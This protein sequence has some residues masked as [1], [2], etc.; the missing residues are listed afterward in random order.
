M[1]VVLLAP[2]E[3]DDAIGKRKE[4]VIPATT[5]ILP[6]GDVSAALTDYDLAGLDGLTTKDLGAQTLGVGVT[7]VTGSALAFLVS[8]SVPAYLCLY[9]YV[10]RASRTK[11]PPCGAARR[12]RVW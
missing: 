12:P 2:L 10:T 11:R 4:G 5:H 7:T 9:A 6:R 1:H 3:L 8:H